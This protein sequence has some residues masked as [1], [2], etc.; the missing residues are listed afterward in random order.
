MGMELVDRFLKVNDVNAFVPE[1]YLASSAFLNNFTSLYFIK[2]I[3][4]LHVTFL[5]LA[6]EKVT[7]RKA[8]TLSNLILKTNL[9]YMINA[10]NRHPCLSMACSTASLPVSHY[11]F[12]L[13]FRV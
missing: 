11:Q 4:G 13:D 5:C 12:K 3:H 6:K 10:M 2:P 1:I 9:N 7:K 8:T